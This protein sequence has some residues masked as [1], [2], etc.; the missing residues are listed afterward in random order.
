MFLAYLEDWQRS[1]SNREGDY[2]ADQ[3][4]RM[5]LSSQTYEG[6]KI[7][8]YSLMEIIPFLLGEG[9]EYVLTERF[10]QDVVED[11]FGHQRGQGGRSDNPD[12]YQF[13]YN[14]FK[15][16]LIIHEQN[17]KKIIAVKESFYV[18]KHT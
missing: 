9:F 14:D 15:N 10:M 3:Q 2:S 13:G 6:S 16:S 18:I 1:I 4:G 11:Y 8:S 12:A 5:F 7:S 17:T